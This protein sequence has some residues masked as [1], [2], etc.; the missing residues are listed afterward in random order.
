MLSKKP[1]HS[2]ITYGYHTYCHVIIFEV[3]LNIDKSERVSATQRHI[4][5]E[6]RSV[7]IFSFQQNLITLLIKKRA[8]YNKCSQVRN[9]LLIKIQLPATSLT[10]KKNLDTVFRL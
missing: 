5:E 3:T 1:D 2:H 6:N 9:Q 10:L 7:R 8:F 4:N